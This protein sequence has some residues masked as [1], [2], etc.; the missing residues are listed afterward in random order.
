MPSTST[1]LR[2][3][4]STGRWLGDLLVRIGRL[5]RGTQA[6]YQA[7]V[8]RIGLAGSV[9]LFL[10]REWPHRRT[11]YGDRS[12]LSWDLAHTL[13]RLEGT[14]TV[15]NWYGGRLWF[16]VVY[17]LAIA[18]A[19]AVLVGWRTR[20]ASVVFMLGMLSLENR[21]TLLGDGGDNLIRIMV[22]YL[23]FTRCAEVWSLDARRAARGPADQQDR[24]GV[25]LWSVTGPLL[26][27]GFGAPTGGWSLVLW[28]LWAGHALWYAANRWFPRHEARAV[29]DDCASMLHNCAMLVIAAQVCLVYA[30]AGW[31]K[32]QG[33]R[34]QDGSA[35][36]YV[37]H[38]D[39]FTPWPWLSGAL[40]GHSLLLLVL[41]YLTVMVQVAFPFTLGARRVKN[42]LLVVMVMEHLGIAVL[43]GI[44]FFSLV[45][46]ACD[47]VFLPTA[48]LVALGGHCTGL[49]SRLRTRRTGR[50]RPV[51]PAV[52]AAAGG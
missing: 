3:L 31:Y 32:I 40:V 39:H 27:W 38:L 44:P 36:H 25:V 12:P 14:F 45:M 13:T 47:A 22:I 49:T 16:E 33:L 11:L 26:A 52:G 28:T 2:F 19:V 7:A 21:N 9:L 30:S 50:A 43:L 18:A 37:M 35:L 48:F 24:T 42:V 23:V 5:A 1:R 34:W 41:G 29:L 8:F 15:L 4:A 10:L 51:E 20:T 17:T 46:I 6:P